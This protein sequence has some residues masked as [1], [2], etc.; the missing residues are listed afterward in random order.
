[1]IIPHEVEMTLERMPLEH[2]VTIT[3]VHSILIVDDTPVSAIFEFA[4]DENGYGLHF[5]FPL[6]QLVQ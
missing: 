2:G 3:G 1:M 5:T 4:P 6:P